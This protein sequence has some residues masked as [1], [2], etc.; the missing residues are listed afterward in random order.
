MK[1]ISKAIAI[2]L[3]L[4]IT[5]AAYAQKVA[6]YSSGTPGTDSY[7]GY[8]FWT[9]NGKP[10]EITFRYGKDRTELKATYAG[11]TT[12]KSKPAFKMLFSNKQLFYVLPTGDKLQIINKKLNKTE[13]FSWEYEGPVNGIGTFCEPCAQDEKEAKI[14]LKKAYFKGL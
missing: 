3:F 9:K 11:K 6:N 14:L 1:L 13:T 10:S 7:Q 2:T 8:S 4:T 12:Y 5:T